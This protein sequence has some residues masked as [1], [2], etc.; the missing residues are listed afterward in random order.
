MS[1]S[2][3]TG[4]DSPATVVSMNAIVLIVRIGILP[5]R[6]KSFGATVWFALNP[7]DPTAR[8][9][10]AKLI[11]NRPRSPERVPASSGTATML[12]QGISHWEPID[13]D[14]AVLW[15]R[16]GL[17]AQHTTEWWVAP[18]F[19]TDQ[20]YAGCPLPQPVEGNGL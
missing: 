15:V 6:L 8:A 12:Y 13:V 9:C 17:D 18:I 10:I 5:D 19:F 3:F 20:T 11:A 16:V 14:G 4:A 1:H 7:A 2:F